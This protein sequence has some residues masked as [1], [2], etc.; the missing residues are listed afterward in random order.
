LPRL[1]LAD[2]AGR[3]YDEPALAM[4]GSSAGYPVR[5][6]AEELI[7]LPEGSTLFTLPGRRPVGWDERRGRFRVVEGT[8]VGAFIAPAY[9]RTLLPAV[10]REAGAP[11]LPLW[12]YSAVGYAGGRFW[13]PAL[14]VDRDERCEPR[15][16][17]DDGPLVHRVREALAE[18][19]ENRL[20]AQLARCALEY[21]CFA[22]K[23]TFNRRWELPLPTSPS[24]NA[25]CLGCISLQPAGCCPSSQ[26]RIAFVPTPEEIAALAVP[27]L[28]RAPWAIVSFGQGC[29]G[30]PLLQAETLE[31]AIRLM[32]ERTSRGTINLNTNGYWPEAVSRLCRAGLDSIRFTL[33]SAI[34]ERYDAYCRPQG[35]SFGDVIEAMRAARREGIWISLNLLVFPGVTD[36]P[37]EIEALVALHREVR[38]DMIQMRNLNIDPEHYLDAL[39]PLGG[40]GIGIRSFMARLRKRCAGLRYG[41]FNP[42]KE[43]FANPELFIRAGAL[44]A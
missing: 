26:E 14:R 34:E 28:E 43:S 5:V 36:R 13:V 39:P 24:C 7:P 42:P 20:L 19:P 4:A 44:G 29:E 12:A 1:V 33:P 23:N 38:Y 37:E 32:R 35:Y 30:E 9:T 17:A 2:E 11:V 8:A 10:E 22:A 27:H 40:P 6:S 25:R 18:Q 41:Y 31:R 15:L 16:Y 3:I 21:H